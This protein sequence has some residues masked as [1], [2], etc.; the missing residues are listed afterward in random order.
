MDNYRHTLYRARRGKIFGVFQ[1]VSNYTGLDAFWLRFFAIILMFFTGIVPMVI[2][3]LVAAL[4]MKLEPPFP[5]EPQQEE[6]YNCVAS[7]RR[8]ALIRLSSRLDSLDRRTQRLETIVTARGSDWD[9]R[10]NDQR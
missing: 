4:L 9:R 10:L 6:F 7:N 2:A 1:G 8:L 3:Y 5:L